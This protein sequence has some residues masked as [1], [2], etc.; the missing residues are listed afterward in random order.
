[1]LENARESLATF[2][3]Q[4][5]INQRRWPLPYTNKF[6]QP[7]PL[8]IGRR[9][10]GHSAGVTDLLFVRSIE[11]FE[12]VDRTKWELESDV[13]NTEETRIESVERKKIKYFFL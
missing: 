4:R 2:K 12:I 7:C 1:M 13:I 8:R 9:I 10:A 5:R 6:Q 3:A 11:T